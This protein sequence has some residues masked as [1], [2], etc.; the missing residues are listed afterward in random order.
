M[1]HQD[2][3]LTIKNL[4]RWYPENAEKVFERFHFDLRKWDFRILMG[5]SAT[6]KSTLVRLIIGEMIPPHGTILYRNDDISKYAE[7]DRENYRKNIWVI[8]Q[9]YRLFDEQ[10]V[11]ENIAAPLRIFGLGESIVEAKIDS[12][13][14]KL[15]LRP[16]INTPIRRL[17]AGEKQKICLARAIV[18][19]PEFIIADEPTGNLD[20][21]HTQEVANILIEA[22]KAGNT[23]LLIT[24]DIHL[25]N[26][27]KDKHTLT[28]DILK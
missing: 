16:I 9:D 17:S 20:R 3:L 1:G 14:K 2:T 26:Y 4:S 15:N 8:F 21:E 10:S 13:I 7:T 23:I 18:H 28:V 24:H 11:Q 6:G 5:K 22:N 25:V 27:L 12:V 19:D